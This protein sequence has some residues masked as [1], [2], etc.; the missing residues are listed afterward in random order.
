MFF[1]IFSFLGVLQKY[2]GNAL[3]LHWDQVTS[4]SDVKMALGRRRILKIFSL[5]QTN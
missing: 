1:L 3:I 5:R 2:C 4:L